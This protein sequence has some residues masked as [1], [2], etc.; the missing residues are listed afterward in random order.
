MI[1]QFRVTAEKDLAYGLSEILE[2]HADV[3]S[4]FE[5]TKKQTIWIVEGVV[6]SEPNRPL[7]EK[8]I[9]DYSVGFET[10]VVPF[11]VGRKS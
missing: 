4:L 1:W 2:E 3:I 10:G 9:T 7:L 6:E 8:A 5:N 11:L